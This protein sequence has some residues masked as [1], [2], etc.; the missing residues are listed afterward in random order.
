MKTALVTGSSRGIGREI[1]K[2][3]SSRGFRVILAARRKQRLEELKCSNPYALKEKLED[4]AWVISR[5]SGLK[6]QIEEQ[7]A[8][9]RAYDDR[10]AE[11]AGRSQNGC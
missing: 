8:A 6:R 10:F 7:K 3:L 2:Q 4:G 5:T 1:A 11:L 9:A